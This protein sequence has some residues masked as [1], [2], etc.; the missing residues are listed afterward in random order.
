[1][2]TN[3]P[4]AEGQETPG[5]P[6]DGTG[7]NEDGTGDEENPPTE[8]CDHS[9]LSYDPNNDGTHNVVCKDCG[10]TIKEDVACTAGSKWESSG[11]NHYKVCTECGGH[12]DEGKHTPTNDAPT[13]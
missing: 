1:L 12:V 7:D 9:N 2:E 5:D 8:P 11:D 4:T 3:P 10:K 6:N 13:F